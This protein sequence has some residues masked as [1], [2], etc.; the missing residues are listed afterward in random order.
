MT[1]AFGDPSAKGRQLGVI[2]GI[3][4]DTYQPEG[5]GIWLNSPNRNLD[6]RKPLDLINEGNGQ[7][8]LDEARRIEGG[9]Y[10]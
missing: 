6:G 1:A 7:R 5:V 10:R 4:L 2:I 8:V 9:A 3:L